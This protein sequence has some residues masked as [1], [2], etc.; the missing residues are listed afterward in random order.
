MWAQIINAL[1]GI[2]LMAAPAILGTDKTI[3]NNENIV[4]PLIASFAIISCWEITRVVRLYNLPLG[5]WLLL[6]PWVLGYH[7]TTATL[8]EMGVGLLVIILCFV[9]GKVEGQYGGGW[10]S[11]WGK[12]PLHEQKAS[13]THSNK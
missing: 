12:N 7:N 8:N 10:S 2:W 5:A 4:G 1:L 3:A 6:A 11:I 13:R 9:K